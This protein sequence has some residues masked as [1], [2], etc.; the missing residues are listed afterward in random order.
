MPRLIVF[1]VVIAIAV[2]AC[3]SGESAVDSAI[4][5]IAHASC[6]TA[7]SCEAI[8]EDKSFSDYGDCMSYARDWLN[9]RW[10]EECG[11]PD[12]DMVTICLI[13]IKSAECSDEPDIE[14]S[15]WFG[16]VLAFC[17][18]SILCTDS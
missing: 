14:V 17:N 3:G 5:R 11:R 15:I 7:D 12:A 8:G 10:P 18:P 9:E 6:D 2:P 16:V 13:L 1:L 4:N